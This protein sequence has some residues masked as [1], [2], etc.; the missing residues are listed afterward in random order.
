MSGVVATLQEGKGKDENGNFAKLEES[1]FAEVD[2]GTC[3]EETSCSLA[4][5][6]GEET[7]PSLTEDGGTIFQISDFVMESS[8]IDESGQ[9]VQAG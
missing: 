3:R 7:F 1:T 9:V 2:E 6:D 8:R 5:V 4:V